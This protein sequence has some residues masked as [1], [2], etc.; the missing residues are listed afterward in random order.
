[1]SRVRLLFLLVAVV[2]S[3]I[4]AWMLAAG[5]VGRSTTEV[6]EVTT[7]PVTEILVANQDMAMGELLLETKAG[8]REWPQANVTPTMIY[9]TAAQ[10]VIL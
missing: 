6:V 8:W 7:V 10:V 5:L 4:V 9:S 3:G 1:M 2:A